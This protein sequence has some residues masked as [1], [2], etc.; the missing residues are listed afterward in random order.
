MKQ[1]VKQI[2]KDYLKSKLNNT[3]F[4]YNLRYNHRKYLFLRWLAEICKENQQTDDVIA[5]IANYVQ[6]EIPRLASM[7]TDIFVIENYVYI[8]TKYPGMWIGKRGS[9][10]DAI[11]DEINNDANGNKMYNYEI[12]LLEDDSSSIYTLQRWAAFYNS[13]Y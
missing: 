4:R 2:I 8:Q 10:I 7:F 11:S 3:T 12:Q 5:S 6:R 9:T 13:N 1:L